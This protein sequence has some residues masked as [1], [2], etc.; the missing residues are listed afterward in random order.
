[1]G[2]EQ[3]PEVGEREAAVGERRFEGRQAGGRP[4]VVQSET[5]VR[6]EQV[7]ADN[8]LG[9]VVEVD[10]VGGVHGTPRS[11]AGRAPGF[12]TPSQASVARSTNGPRYQPPC[13]P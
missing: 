9:L 1:M 13:V 6:F 5:V 11:Y 10:Q 12:G 3:V 4:T 7:A 2:E 8:A